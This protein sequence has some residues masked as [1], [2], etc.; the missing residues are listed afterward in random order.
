MDILTIGYRG[1]VVEFRLGQ[2]VVGRI[3]G[4]TNLHFE[5]SENNRA[6]HPSLMIYTEDY[7]DGE[8]PEFLNQLKAGRFIRDYTPFDFNG[9][10]R[11]DIMLRKDRDYGLALL[12]PEWAEEEATEEPRD[13]K[14]IIKPAEIEGES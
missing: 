2:G 5:A 12:K 1:D 3:T 9:K 8:R 4:V 7:P 10:R 14:A 11:I 13:V 6:I